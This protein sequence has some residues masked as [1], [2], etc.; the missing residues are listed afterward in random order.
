MNIATA[1][2]L[3]QA[4]DILT[5][6]MID[7]KLSEYRSD[8]I[9]IS[10]KFQTLNKRLNRTYKQRYSETINNIADLTLQQVREARIVSMQY[11]VSKIKYECLEQAAKS[12]Q[13]F[14]FVN[15]ALEIHKNTSSKNKMFTNDMIEII[16]ATQRFL[17]KYDCQLNKDE[18]LH[19]I[20]ICQ[21]IYKR[22]YEVIFKE[23]KRYAN[24]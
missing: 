11:L 7:I 23:I 10:E 15:D 2:L 8:I 5:E 17:T 21:P 13:I 1:V 19:D 16:D 20:E 24:N 18:V 9:I 4:A 12:I 3:Q 22:M 6:L 14:V